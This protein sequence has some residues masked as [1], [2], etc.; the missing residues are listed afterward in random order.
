MLEI[1][2]ITFNRGEDG[3]IIAQEVILDL[4]DKPTVRIKPITRGK[5]QEIF[6]M[7]KSEDKA[8]V[9]QADNEII[10]NGLVEP[11]LNLEQINDLQPKYSTA[12]NLAILSISLGIDAKDIISAMRMA[13]SKEIAL[14]KN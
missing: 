4:P 5:L 2:D 13:E 11:E 10:L 1:K 7:A 6:Q 9:I 12:I 3:N 8:K 14:K